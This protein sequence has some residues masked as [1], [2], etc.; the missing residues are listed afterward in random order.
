MVRRPMTYELQKEIDSLKQ[1][2]A[3]AK[4]REQS[5]ED[6]LYAA[7]VILCQAGEG[8]WDNETLQWKHDANRW[9][10]QY[11]DAVNKAMERI[12]SKAKPD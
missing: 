8:D 12:A 7:N 1:Q 5:L 11:E 6:G 9:C 2:L 4:A 3:D 10:C